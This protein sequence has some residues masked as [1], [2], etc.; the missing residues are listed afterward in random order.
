MSAPVAHPL[1]KLGHPAPL[2]QGQQLVHKVHGSAAGGVHAAEE[3]GP[4]GGLGGR[5]AQGGGPGH[6]HVAHGADLTI[7]ELRGGEQAAQHG[8]RAHDGCSGADLAVVQLR[9][10]GAGSTAWVY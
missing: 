8:V 3:G 9:E 4:G 1:P 5:K 2:E 7:V 6:L 10:G